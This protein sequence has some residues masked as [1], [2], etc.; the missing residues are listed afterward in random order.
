[1]RFISKVEF[2][3]IFVTLIRDESTQ[4]ESIFYV[5]KSED[6]VNVEIAFQYT[7][8]LQEN[9][10]GFANN[11]LTPGGGTHII[12]FSKAMT[13]VLN[14]YAKKK[15]ILKEKDGTLTGDDTKE[16]LTSVVSVKIEEPQFEG[17]TK[18]KLGNPEVKGI[19]ESIFATA[20]G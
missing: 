10:H 20:L 16:G 3:P 13:R 5:E 9:T 2:N 1:M 18:D 6:N 15:N 4:H 19:V 11:I 8:N 7:D 17:Q 14:S 12:G